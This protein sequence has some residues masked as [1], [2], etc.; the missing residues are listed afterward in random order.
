MR[1]MS[2]REVLVAGA[3]AA[4]VAACGGDDGAAAP[5]TSPMRAAPSSIEY[6]VCTCRWTN[7]SL[8]DMERRLPV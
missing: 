2:R 1:P 7:E 6:S 3:A 4:M 5:T 8:D